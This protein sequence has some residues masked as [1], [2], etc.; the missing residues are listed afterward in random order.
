MKV[1]VTLPAV[2]P[3]VAGPTC[4]PGRLDR[5]TEAPS[6]DTAESASDIA[7][8]SEYRLLYTRHPSRAP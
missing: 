7:L 4:W 8:T 3:D 2:I 6:S 1:A 5:I